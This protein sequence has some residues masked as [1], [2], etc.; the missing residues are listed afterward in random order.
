LRLIIGWEVTEYTN[1]LTESRVQAIDR[2]SKQ[3][4]ETGADGVIGVRFENAAGK[5]GESQILAY[6]TA[7]KLK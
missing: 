7:V 1:L 4:E 5:N 3:A 6:G 2:M